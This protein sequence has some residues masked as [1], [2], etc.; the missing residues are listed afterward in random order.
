MV[1]LLNRAHRKAT[2]YTRQERLLV[3][4]GWHKN[5]LHLAEYSFHDLLSQMVHANKSKHLQQH[6][7]LLREQNPSQASV[8]SMARRDR[9][10]TQNSIRRAESPYLHYLLPGMCTAVQTG[11]TSTN[12]KGWTSLH[13]VF[14]FFILFQY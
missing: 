3:G 10:C 9:S 13:L 4:R 7:P 11:L 5:K 8:P 2:V 1:Y 6:C 14:P 12:Q